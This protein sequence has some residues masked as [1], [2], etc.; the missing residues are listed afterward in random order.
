MK[1]NI[2]IFANRLL[3]IS[4]KMSLWDSSYEIK[5][6]PF[7]WQLLTD[8]QVILWYKKKSEKNKTDLA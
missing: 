2:C 5:R 6:L 3:Y 7:N 8:T 1:E 4:G